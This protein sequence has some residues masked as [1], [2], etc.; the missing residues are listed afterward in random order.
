[1][2]A[3]LTSPNQLKGC[4]LEGERNLAWS[5]SPIPVI[6]EVTFSMQFNARRLL[7]AT[8][9]I[10][11]YGFVPAARSSQE[12]DY[13]EVTSE[14]PRAA[15]SPWEAVE[16]FGHVEPAFEHLHHSTTPS[17]SIPHQSTPQYQQSKRGAVSAG[18]SSTHNHLTSPI[19]GMFLQRLLQLGLV[20]H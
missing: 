4:V 3:F 6:Y 9:P 18:L 11:S 7:Q 16:Q 13:D 17:S 14:L 2:F 10:R 19:N 12:P 20:T 5:T 8:K 15:M 1:M